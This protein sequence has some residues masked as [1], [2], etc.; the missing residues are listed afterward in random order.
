MSINVEFFA[1]VDDVIHERERN[2]DNLRKA[3]GYYF[4]KDGNQIDVY[5]KLKSLNHIYFI[6]VGDKKVK[7]NDIEALFK[8]KSDLNISFSIGTDKYLLIS[9][10]FTDKQQLLI[11][12]DI[13]SKFLCE[14]FDNEIEF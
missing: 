11:A 1:K 8:S 13:L 4:D 6:V 3:E 10:Q 2:L 14:I 12:I 7:L 9:C 5:Y